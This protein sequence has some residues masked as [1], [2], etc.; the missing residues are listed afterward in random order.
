MISCHVGATHV[1]FSQCFCFYSLSSQTWCSFVQMMCIIHS[2]AIYFFNPVKIQTA[3]C[4]KITHLTKK[5]TKNSKNLLSPA[6][7]SQSES[8]INGHGWNL[9]L[10]YNLTPVSISL[11]VVISV[12]LVCLAITTVYESYKLHSFQNHQIAAL[13]TLHDCLS[14]NGVW[15]LEVIRVCTL[16]ELLATGGHTL[17]DISLG[18]IPDMSFC[19]PNYVIVNKTHARSDMGKDARPRARQELFPQKIDVCKKLA[20]QVVC[21]L[22]CSEKLRKKNKNKQI[23]Q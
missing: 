22:I 6:P 20:I 12:F 2:S 4:N 11:S 16:H 17:R 10:L 18:G 14:Y 7:F 8:N 9:H 21:A 23:I 19:S 5:R 3:I 13:I 1:Q 15:D